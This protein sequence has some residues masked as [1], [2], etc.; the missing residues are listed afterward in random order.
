MELA[1]KARTRG[2]L[3]GTEES[4]EVEMLFAIDPNKVV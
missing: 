2:A 4:G 3:E 1:T